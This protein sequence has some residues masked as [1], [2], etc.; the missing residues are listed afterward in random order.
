MND[1]GLDQP[2]AESAEEVQEERHGESYR[3]REAERA[4]L[5]PSRWWF[6]ST[7]FPLLA[8]T[9]GPMASA[10]NICALIQHWRVSI[11]PGFGAN[12]SH[13][14]DVR[15]PKW[16]LAVNGLSL[17]FALIANFALLLNMARRLAFS[18]AQ[19]ITIVGWYLASILLIGDLTAII[20]IV[21]TPGERRALTQAF[22]Y[23]IFACGIYFIIASLMIFTVY[24]AYKGHYSKE[25]KLSM[26]Q[27]TLML[28]TI[29]FMIY[30]VGGAGVYAKIEGWMFLDALYFTNYTLL[31]IG[32]GDYAP[33]TNLG[34]GL[35][36]PYAIGGIVI[37]GLVIGSIR[38]LVL[39]RGKK[40]LGSRM[41]E[42]KRK[43]HIKK[44]LKKKKINKLTPI[45]D[46]QQADVVGMSERDRRQEEF[47]LMRQIQD[48]AS[49]RQKWQ[50]LLVSGSAWFFLWFIGALIFH[51]AE[52]EQQWTYFGSLYFAYTTLLTIGYGDYKPFSNSGKAFFV[53]WSLLAVPTLTILIS[54]MGDTVV[55]GIR[56][57]TLYL[58]EIT[59][60]P[61]EEGLRSRV[62]QLM[63]QGTRGKLFGDEAD[64]SDPPPGLLGGQKETDAE[65]APSHPAGA[66]ARGRDFLAGEVQDEELK[67]AR[68][69]K[70]RGDKLGE[71]IHEYHYLLVQE[72][73]NVMKHVRES[74]PRKYTYEE[75]EWFLKLIGEN[76]SNSAFHRQA[77]VDV[78]SDHNKKPDI[79]HPTDGD[80]DQVRQ[81]SWIGSRSPL[82]GETEEAEWVLERLS[83]TLENELKKQNE[84]RRKDGDKDPE[85]ADVA[86]HVMEPQSSSGSSDTVGGGRQGTSG[87]NVERETK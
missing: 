68:E 58:G 10:F 76:E 20:H 2:I 27:R 19:P 66:Q 35:L 38:S 34:R 74:P 50:A 42:K 44:M 55:K 23:A 47:N 21:K 83:M 71:N 78:K 3:E 9:F 22:Y 40:K 54:N 73:R 62:K 63:A 85:S 75:W 65:Q 67:E 11:P 14:N 36:F 41:V 33:S 25:F 5:D 53:F 59:V 52:H 12:E 46:K 86:K 49:A 56:D 37:L 17:G 31:T 7:A 72:F 51:F 8:G 61:G 24:G 28:Q 16:L 39:E 15:D 57:L 69:A 87:A 32:I 82:M 29:S 80:N 77:P 43:Q 48:E 81:W 18:I 1:P 60:L 26:S 64:I 70:R 13:G 30:M 45:E 79:Q 84:A 4:F 6:A